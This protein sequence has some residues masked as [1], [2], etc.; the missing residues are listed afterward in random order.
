M[1]SEN[2]HL[3]RAHD[4]AGLLG[5]L[6]SFQESLSSWLR[7]A[8]ERSELAQLDPWTQRDLGLSESD[9]WREANKHAW[10]D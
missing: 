10:E 1:E 3:S 5:T 4:R 2:L 6:H 9:I 8:R 7:R